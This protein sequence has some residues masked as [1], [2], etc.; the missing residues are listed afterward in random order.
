MF[1][2]FS[3]QSSLVF[4]NSAKNILPE[5]RSETPPTAINVTIPTVRS[6]FSYRVLRYNSARLKRYFLNKV[7]K[8]QDLFCLILL[9][10]C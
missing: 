5:L 10:K 4:I 3:Q 2:Q 8:F 6:I 9:V 1:T 7:I